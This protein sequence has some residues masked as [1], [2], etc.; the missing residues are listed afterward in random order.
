MSTS[1]LTPPSP[2][3]VLTSAAQAA[4]RAITPDARAEVAALL[5]SS[6]QQAAGQ[7]VAGQMVAGQGGGRRTLGE[8]LQQG[9]TAIPAPHAAMDRPT[10]VEHL[11][12]VG[13]L[14]EQAVQAD[15]R[16]PER[17]VRPGGRRL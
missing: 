8:Q 10:G 6:I 17:A 2:L 14:L 9:A 13:T 3:T 4:S 12:L 16:T 11:G 15:P 7:M 1:A 5:R